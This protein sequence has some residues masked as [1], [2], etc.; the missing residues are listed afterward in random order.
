[1]TYKTIL[2]HL[3]DVE[4]APRLVEAAVSMADR[5]RAHLIG[6]AV[7]PPFVVV[8]AM[9]G[10][11]VTVSVDQHRDAYQSDMAALKTLFTKATEGRTFQ[12]EWR[13]ADAGFATAAG[14]IIEQARTADIV[15]VNQQDPAWRYSSM[16]EEPERIAIE[17]GRPLLLIPN[18]GKA[19]M[20]PKIVT[21]AW[22]ARREATRA[23]F[24]AMPLL[25]LAESVNV[26]WI[27]PEKEPE[28]AGD[29][30]AAELCAMLSRQGIKCV[31]SQASAIGADVGHE[32]LRQSQA[33]GSD[34]LVM[35]CYG[36]SRLRE[37]ILGGASK[38]IMQHTQL[39]VLLSH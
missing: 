11:G 1:M 33:F 23:V 39:P 5:M 12:S 8:P 28:V 36:H 31:A 9:D 34:L 38:H 24:D 25:Q 21:I 13:E 17:C 19:A 29:V 3:A 22:N 30:P 16:L 35:G 7:M 20:P 27:N 4:R 37:F 2:V 15:I 14:V 6:L 32:L 10:T 18:F 26:V